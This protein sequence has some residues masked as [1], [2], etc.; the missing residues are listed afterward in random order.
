M[1]G[2]FIGG[3]PDKLP[4]AT[5]ATTPSEPDHSDES[6]LQKADRLAVE[7]K[8]SF[9]TA[10][11]VASRQPV[12]LSGAKLSEAVAA[13][14]ASFTKG[15]RVP[16]ISAQG[17][18]GTVPAEQ[19]AAAVAKGFRIDDPNNI[20]A[21]RMTSEHPT[22]SSAVAAIH[23]GDEALLNIPGAITEAV[24]PGLKDNPVVAATQARSVQEHPIASGAGRV[25]GE[26]AM[27]VGTAGLG[28]LGGLA[29][30]AEGAA[31]G[32]K[33]TGARALLDAAKLA[34]PR[35]PALPAEL[36][37]GAKA[38]SKAGLATLAEEATPS[39]A[40]GLAAAAAKSGVEGALVSLPQAGKHVY[41]GD[42]E[43]AA[44]TLMWGAGIGAL[45][46]TAL[47]GATGGLS[48]GVAR[49]AED[50][51]ASG[52]SKF[53]AAPE[54]YAASLAGKA[55]S[56]G[57]GA[58]LGLKGVGAYLVNKE[59]GVT[60]RAGSWV[61]NAVKGWLGSDQLS[62][63]GGGSSKGALAR[64]WLKSLAEAPL[65]RGLGEG[66]AMQAS[67]VLGQRL[68]NVPTYIA[69]MAA[70]EGPHFTQR[71]TFTPDETA[72]I[73]KQ[74]I[75][76]AASPEALS[77]LTSKTV[78]PLAHSESSD[79]VSLALQGKMAT[80]VHYI[81]SQAPKPD[82]TPVPFGRAQAWQPTGLELSALS[83]KLEVIHDPFTVV[84]RMAD[85][86]LTQDHID[87][88]KAVYPKT[89]ADLQKAIVEYSSHP[90]AP[91]LTLASR[92]K[93]GTLMGTSLDPLNTPEAVRAL[94]QHFGSDSADA[95]NGGK[96]GAKP[97]AGKTPKVTYEKFPSTATP[98]QNLEHTGTRRGRR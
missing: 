69:A 11:D 30:A 84:S 13:G 44:E 5:V 61:E 8:A 78:T 68:A 24:V 37:A 59:L 25:A 17:Q 79:A 38:L 23:G 71:K 95:A 89:Y 70:N 81:A 85:G 7:A 83:R 93:L 94:Q 12:A 35:W 32:E 88:L 47:K 77:D 55:T 97:N 63:F 22:W 91:Q 1:A 18:P 75:E 21:R 51:V 19:L 29:K 2:P 36:E 27:A 96:K 74:S 20:A 76:L 82:Q 40:R 90:H 9:P 26:V 31:L 16:V 43:K 3:K 50:A 45:F 62:L 58:A 4:E 67:S 48:S 87:A 15:T 72:R 66:L 41:D 57:L 39:F 86:S 52:L 56:K 46:G 42:P 73:V 34:A 28:K 54:E 6:Y 98:A 49:K 92:S 10:Y 64:T 65:E 80:T 53:A 14:Q 60:E 33:V